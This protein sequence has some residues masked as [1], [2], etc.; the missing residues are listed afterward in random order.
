MECEM[1][2]NEMKLT[3]AEVAQVD[4]ALAEEATVRPELAAMIQRADEMSFLEESWVSDA[5]DE[6]TDMLRMEVDDLFEPRDGD[7]GEFEPDY[8]GIADAVV[9]RLKKLGY[10]REPESQ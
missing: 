8:L 1:D 7:F 9:N 4:A 10:L 6:I 3:P 2:E 5:K